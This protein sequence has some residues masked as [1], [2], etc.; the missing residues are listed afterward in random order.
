MRIYIHT[1]IHTYG[2]LLF[3]TCFKNISHVYICIAGITSKSGMYSEVDNT[4]LIS[5]IMCYYSLLLKLDM[6]VMLIKI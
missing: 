1:H 2:F 4:L 6:G 3:V 5:R